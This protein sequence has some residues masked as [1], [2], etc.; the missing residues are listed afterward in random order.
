MNFKNHIAGIFLTDLRA[1]LNRLC[2]LT[3]IL[4]LFGQLP[5]FLPRFGM[6]F[7][8]DLIREFEDVEKY[9]CSSFVGFPFASDIV[10]IC[11]GIFHLQ[12]LH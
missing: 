7:C 12:N 5:S 3:V 10:G 6:Q 1:M 11:I 8:N 9:C 2:E 4:P